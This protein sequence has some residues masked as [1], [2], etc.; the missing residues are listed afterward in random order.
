MKKT[1]I[2]FFVCSLFISLQSSFAMEVPKNKETSILEITDDILTIVCYQVGPMGRSQ[3]RSVCLKFKPFIDNIRACISAGGKGWT[4]TLPI[5]ANIQVNKYPQQLMEFKDKLYVS[6]MDD[7]T[8]MVIDPFQN[9]L[10]I[11]TIEVDA[12]PR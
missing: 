10:V 6:N 3:L 5:V 7:N 2:L 11:H 12:G 4:D 8:V 1:I 9:H